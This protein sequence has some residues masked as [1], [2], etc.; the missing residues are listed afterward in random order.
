ML[1]TIVFSIVGIYLIIV[2]YA[3]NGLIT[4]AKKAVKVF[5]SNLPGVLSKMRGTVSSV[6]NLIVTTQECLDLIRCK[7]ISPLYSAVSLLDAVKVG[8]K[9]WR[10]IRKEQSKEEPAKTESEPAKADM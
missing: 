7:I 3:A 9:A 8:Y 10:I 6:E 4:E 5:N 2:L 1:L